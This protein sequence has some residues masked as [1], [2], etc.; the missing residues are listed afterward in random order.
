[1]VAGA[2]GSGQPDSLES[3]IW[4][5][6]DATMKPIVGNKRIERPL[7]SAYAPSLLPFKPLASAAVRCHNPTALPEAPKS[8]QG[9]TRWGSMPCLELQ[10][11]S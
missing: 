5:P 8:L 9:N 2:E 1:M 7:E 11:T 3:L 10:R 4:H 6:T